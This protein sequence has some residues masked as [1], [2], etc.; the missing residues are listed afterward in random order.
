MSKQITIKNS[1][2][3]ALIVKRVQQI[4]KHTRRPVDPHK[5][6][7]KYLKKA[8]K[9]AVEDPRN[10]YYA[11]RKD[12]FEALWTLRP[13]YCIYCGTFLYETNISL[14]HLTPLCRGGVPA[15]IDNLGLACCNCNN[16]KHEL[17]EDEY[18]VSKLL[19]HLA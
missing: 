1:E 18:R 9:D 10:I 19:K 11:H 2:T 3:I 4:Q 16:E 17:T 6:V 12:L 13:H 5:V 8:L 15:A 7:N 14:D